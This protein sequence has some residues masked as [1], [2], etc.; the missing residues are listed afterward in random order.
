MTV[1]AF[2]FTGFTLGSGLNRS[3]ALGSVFKCRPAPLRHTHSASLTL[4]AG[5][6]CP[7]K[8]FLQKI[9]QNC[10]L[11]VTAVLKYSAGGVSSWTGSVNSGGFIC[12]V[13]LRLW[14]GLPG[15]ST[16][17]FPVPSFGLFL[18]HCASCFEASPVQ[19]KGHSCCKRLP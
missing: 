19:E 17:S 14:P 2:G 15:F 3:L 11:K 12:V 5:C 16:R 13:S 6:A 18:H 7:I 1:G 8:R 10:A 4:T 9:A